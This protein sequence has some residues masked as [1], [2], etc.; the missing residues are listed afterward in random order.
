M[1]RTALMIATFAC[2]TLALADK[3]VGADCHPR[4]AI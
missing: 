4:A 2:P 1:L 3:T